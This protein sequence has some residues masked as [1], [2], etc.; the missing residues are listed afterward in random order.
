MEPVLSQPLI[1]LILLHPEASPA[2]AGFALPLLAQHALV[3][4]AAGFALP[5]LAQHAL[6]PA[7][8]GFA[9]AAFAARAAI[10]HSDVPAREQFAFFAAQ[11][12][13]SQFAGSQL[14]VLHCVAAVAPAFT[15]SVLLQPITAKPS[16]ATRVSVSSCFIV[17]FSKKGLKG[18]VIRVESYIVLS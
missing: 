16:T 3:P 14:L 10:G 9:F 8:A 17:I 2:A 11:A 15:F 4:A 13:M 1:S 6:V 18:G 5:L 12:V 7:A